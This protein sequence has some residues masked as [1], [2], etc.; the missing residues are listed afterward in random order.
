MGLRVL[1]DSVIMIDHLNGISRATRYL[2]SI[3]D[4]VIS[5]VTRAEVL[6]GITD[7]DANTIAWLDWFPTIGIDQLTADV[8]AA[9][10]RKYRWRLPDAFQAAIAE[11]HGLK[12][13]T[14]NTRDF[15]PKTHSFVVVPYTL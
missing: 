6:T 9:L 3:D 7:T 12:L 10:R 2:R 15:P 4:G 13:A 11:V 8:A 1:F 5:V 14:R